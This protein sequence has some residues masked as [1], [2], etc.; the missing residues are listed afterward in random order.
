MSSYIAKDEYKKKSVAN[1]YDADRFKSFFGRLYDRLEKRAVHRALKT[2][3]SSSSILDLPCGTG[4]FTELLLNEGYL[5][6]ASDI[7]EQMLGQ[8]RKRIGDNDKLQ[9]LEVQDAENL[10]LD[11]NT[12]DCVLTIR[13]LGH[14]PPDVRKKILSEIERVT[15]DK[16]IVAFYLDTPFTPLRVFLRRLLTGKKGPWFPHLVTR[17]KLIEELE[18]A[19]MA[20]LRVYPVAT[21]LDPSRVFLVRKRTA[22]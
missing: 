7:S 15:K 6:T 1:S 21:F 12:F 19:N 14:V 2:I 16:C 9:R 5:V 20:V 18:V 22:R 13:L 10:G 8:T 11:D 4:R 17:K 3:P